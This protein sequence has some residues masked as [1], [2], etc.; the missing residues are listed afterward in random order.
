MRNAL[1]GPEK[2]VN[3]TKIQKRYKMGEV[4]IIS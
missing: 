1:L 3:Y 4:A 2:A